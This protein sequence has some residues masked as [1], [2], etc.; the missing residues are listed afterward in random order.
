MTATRPPDLRDV[1]ET[2]AEHL[3]AE[4]GHVESAIDEAAGVVLLPA[5]VDRPNE[6][7]YAIA[8]AF[9][10]IATAV[11]VGGV[12]TGASARFYAAFAGLLGI[13][14]ALLV[15]RVKQPVASYAL[16]LL[17]LFGIGVLMVIPNGLANVTSIGSLASSAARS[18]NVLRPP[19]SLNPGW[20]AIIGWLMGVVGFGAAWLAVSV[21]RAPVALLAPLPIAAIAGISVPSTAQIASG[22]VVLVLFAIGLGILSTANS[23][24]AEGDQPPLTYE[25]RRAVRAIPLLAITTLV[26]YL[27]AQA[28]ILFP[29]PLIDPSNEPQ[30]PR[31]AP[32]TAVEDRVL[33]EVTS[34]ATGPWRIGSL[35]VYDGR[36]WRLPPFAQNQLDDVPRNGIV[37]PKL[38]RGVRATFTIAG[39]GGAVL[40]TLPNTVGVVAKGPR[41][42]YDARNG[43]L[44]L[45]EGQVQAGL[46]YTVVAATLPT[47]EDL[48][49]ITESIPGPI[50][51]FARVPRSGEPTPALKAIIEQAPTTSKWD[52]FNYL[53][54]YV[55]DNVTA[56]GAGRP[57]SVTV[58][59]VEDM[60]TGS[61]EGSPFEI[62]AAQALLARWIGVPSRIGYGFDGGDPVGS[63]LQVRPRN[64]AT[65]VEVYFPGF[66][67]LPII[68]VPRHAKPTVG[69]NSGQSQDPSIV[70]SDDIAIE[71]F[72]PVL[73]PAPSVF[74]KQ[75]QR[76]VLIALP[77]LAA[78]A[79]A[80]VFY[81]AVR[82]AIIRSRRR[83]AAAGLGPR[84]RVAVA[85]ADWRDHAT[86]FGYGYPSDTPIMFLD[87]FVDDADHTEFAWLV[88]RALWGDMQET[89]TPDVVA[90]AEELS[91]SLRRRLA[92]TQPATVRFVAIASRLSLRRP[93][94]PELD[95][96]IRK[97]ADHELVPV[98]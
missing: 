86:D 96:A 90:A 63:R 79:L 84:A 36:D 9:P 66:E 95:V 4:A 67:W 57:V 78:I 94:A 83:R 26:L 39:L 98:G 45:V 56:V 88:T 65:F 33:F 93:Y 27:L 25:L 80:I 48:R 6:L 17:G 82:K 46:E 68:G 13:A 7:R 29:H 38:A 40:P 74:T 75:L 55:L 8:V 52:Q 21:D 87:R 61:K 97:E 42:A 59:R 85:Y 72:L 53:R 30:R 3:A 41:L 69:N 89:M 73:T 32:L 37:N 34:V 2:A 62:V 11:M 76:G 70:P 19:V 14:L 23:A 49:A 51:Q 12:F 1:E 20:Q 71:L 22:I 15:A 54:N 58:D 31:T 47:E 81:P 91:R 10:V 60:L 35:D 77:I 5:K 28:D 50:R 24:S 43:N 18:G 64:G 16:M 92:Q 44:R